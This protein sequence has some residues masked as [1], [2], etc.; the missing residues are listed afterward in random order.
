MSFFNTKPLDQ[1]LQEQ[2]QL[3]FLHYIEQRRRVAFLE[4]GG[5]YLVVRVYRDDHPHL[6]LDIDGGPQAL[7]VHKNESL[8]RW[9]IEA[10]W[11]HGWSV[12]T[13]E[14]RKILFFTRLKETS[15]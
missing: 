2:L 6:V 11:H 10:Y 13:S 12:N 5:D 7:S 15:I 14:D 3:A 1:R 4:R 9:L 8:F